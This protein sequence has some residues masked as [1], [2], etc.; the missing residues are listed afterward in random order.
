MINLIEGL[1]RFARLGSSELRRVRLSM[2]ELAGEALV[3][4]AQAAARAEVSIGA[5]PECDGDRMLLGQVWVNLIGNAFKYSR[6]A[7]RPRIEVGWDERKA[8]YY[9]RDNGIGFNMEYA[10]KLFGVF[11]RLH[12]ELEFEGS[13]IGLAIAERIVKRHGGAIWAHSADGAGATFWFTVP[14]PAPGGRS[15]SG[16]NRPAGNLEQLHGAEGFSPAAGAAGKPF[17]DNA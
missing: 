17:T 3:D 13:G 9:V 8:A 1:L 5:L 11:E 7:E 12:H 6:N 10:A 4:F 14:P 2:N 16:N 15:S